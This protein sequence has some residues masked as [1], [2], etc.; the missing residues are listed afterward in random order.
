NWSPWSSGI[1]SPKGARVTSPA[2]RFIQWKATLTG[3]GAKSP[4]LDSIDVA[5]LPKNLEPRIDEIE[6]TPANFKFPP[7]VTPLVTVT[8]T[9]SLPPIGKRNSSTPS[10]GSDLTPAMQYAKGWIGARWSASDPNGDP[11]VFTI[12]I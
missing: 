9:L 6:A 8:P 4:D 2:A 5:Y 1:T 11:L 12:E 7:P 3:D 10:L